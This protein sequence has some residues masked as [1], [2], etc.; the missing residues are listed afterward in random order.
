M[1]IVFHFDGLNYSVFCVCRHHKTR[2]YVFHSLV[3]I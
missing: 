2:S 3:V 1:G